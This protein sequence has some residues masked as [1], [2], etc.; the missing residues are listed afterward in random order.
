MRPPRRRC[1]GTWDQPGHVTALV[2]AA[3]TVMN[4]YAYTPFGER[5]HTTES[6]QQPLQFMGRERDAATGLYYVRARWYDPDLARFISEDP[7]GLEGGINTYAYALND[8]VNLRDPSGLRAC[9]SIG[10][11][12]VTCGKLGAE[13]DAPWW[14]NLW[15]TPGADEHDPTHGRPSSHSDVVG[16]IAEGKLGDAVNVALECGGEVLGLSD[17]LDVGM[18]AAGQP[19]PG[20]KRFQTPGSSRGTSVAGLVADVVFGDAELPRRV[21]TLVGGPGT[22]RRLA[23]SYSKKAARVAARGVPIIGWGLLAVDAV[24]FGMC[25]LDR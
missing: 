12:T 21:P 10:P 8:P 22:G 25:A 24:K 19:I 18:I 2:N 16:R 6:V 13:V 23:V 7:I 20:T 11:R 4:H 17:L 1:A 14:H 5:E 9:T 3:G 15:G